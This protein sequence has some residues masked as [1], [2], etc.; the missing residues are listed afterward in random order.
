M[1]K[2]KY[3]E[4][5]L[6]MLG[7]IR[8]FFLLKQNSCAAHRTFCYFELCSICLRKG[9]G[10]SKPTTNPWNKHKQHV[11]GDFYYIQALQPSSIENNEHYKRERVSLFILDYVQFAY[12]SARSRCYRS[13]PWMIFLDDVKSYNTI[14]DLLLYKIIL[15]YYSKSTDVK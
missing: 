12:G 13:L 14:K 8:W 7:E 9:L 10:R 1:M 6:K 5:N 2:K 11:C 4:A 15:I 3:L